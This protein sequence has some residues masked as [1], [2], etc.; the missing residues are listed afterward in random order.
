MVSF[1]YLLKTILF[2]HWFSIQMNYTDLFW[3]LN[4]SCPGK[5]TQ[6]S[7]TYMFLPP[8]YVVRREGTVFTGVCLSTGGG[9]GGYRSPGTPPGGGTEVRV[10]PQ[11]GGWGT[12]VW[13]PPRGVP[14]SGYPPG[15]GTKVQVPPR[16]EGGTEVRVPPQGGYRSLG[17][18]PGVGGSGYPPGGVPKSGYPPGGGT[19]VW[20]PPPRGGYR[21]PGRTT[22]GVLTT[23]R[24]VC[25]LAF[26]QE[27]FLVN[28]EIIFHGSSGQ[29]KFLTNMSAKHWQNK[30]STHTEKNQPFVC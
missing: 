24:A 16:G 8:A 25:L 29:S 30:Q 1:L 3:A 10:P 23:R 7:L 22:E 26:T 21:S 27:D 9:R 20:V 19:E 13:V 2:L 18:P 28:L 12:K 15:G 17:T 5:W 6:N 14:K 4:W 11:G